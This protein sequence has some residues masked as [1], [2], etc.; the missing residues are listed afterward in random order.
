MKKKIL[1]ST[2]LASV[3]LTSV[4]VEAQG[5]ANVSLISENKVQVGDTFKV[6]LQVSDIND[7]YD[8]VVSMGGH[9]SFD[10][11]KL[12]FVSAK[13]MEEPYQFQ[14]NV[15]TMM[16][17]G[18]D[19]TLRNGLYETTTVYE[20]TFRALEE[21]MTNITLEKAKLTDSQGYITNTVI[22]KNIE[23]V[24]PIEVKE[25]LS[26][27]SPVVVTEEVASNSKTEIVS[28]TREVESSK[29]QTSVYEEHKE[30]E[31]AGVEV[32]HTTSSQTEVS[33][34]KGNIHSEKIQKV[35]QN[36]ILKLKN[37]F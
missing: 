21:G 27:Q 10:E 3:L 23:I 37:W 17:A 5:T 31:K 15:N 7:T 2:I 6:S 18:L 1:F 9:L 13:P 32:I 8:G 26:I 35:F 33:P 22:D 34:V 4:P 25:E 20:F 36:F 19:F 11:E 28:E 24:E 14:M 16:I 29:K 30:K 12:E